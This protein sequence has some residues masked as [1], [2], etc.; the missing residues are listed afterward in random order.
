MSTAEKMQFQA[1]ARQVLDLMI[2]S[3]YTNK[4]IFLRELISNASDA[5]DRLRVESLTQKNILGK[6]EIFEIVIETDS[7]S[8]TVTVHDSGIGMTR[9]EVIENIGTIAKSGTRELLE[10]L[11]DKPN[12]LAGK[13]IGQFGVGFYAAFMVADKVSLLTRR[14]GQ[15]GATL[16]ESEGNGEYTISESTKFR[17]G[18][19]VTLH[20][21][22]KD[23]E[24]GVEDFTAEYVVGRIV[25]QYSDFVAYP[26]TL[27]AAGKKEKTGADPKP[28]NSMKPIWSRPASEVTE[29]DYTEFYKHISHDWNEPLTHLSFKAEGRIEYQSLL[30]LPSKAPMDL[31]FDSGKFGLQLYVRNVLI[32][33]SCEDLLPRYLRFVKG[34]VDSSDLPLNI[35]RQRLQEDRHIAQ[36]RKWITKKIIDALSDMA[37]DARDKYE[38]FWG[39]FGRV[40]KEGV[41]FD[42]GIDAGNDSGSKARLTP[43]L[44]FDSSVETGKKTTLAEYVERMQPEQ[45]NIFYLTGE[46]RETIEN[47]PHLEAFREKKIEVLFLTD[48]IDEM[49]VQALS[50]FDGKALKSVGKGTVA[51]GS[52]E[53]QN[54]ARKD[55][56]ARQVEYLD[57]MT[58]LKAKL[59]NHVKEVRLTNRLTDSPACLVVAEEDMSPR[60]ERILQMQGGTAPKQRRIMELNPDHEIVMKLKER[61]DGDKDDEAIDDFAELLFGGALLAEGSELKDPGRFSQS[62][63]RLMTRNL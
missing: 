43:L 17:R 26:I 34:V 61:V 31:F 27:E 54:Q 29:E 32:M 45:K 10:T 37:R 9:E 41:G 18:T 40:L 60:L 33:E 3:L 16:W 36:I 44:L 14:A 5:L 47:S 24:S 1:E 21:K 8:R 25:K 6:D 38:D 52:D 50:E 11:K 59:D 53:E 2:H 15:D 58:L 35:S 28:I 23:E 63:S 55:L 56:N 4:D 30:Y 46:S 57:L 19:S 22:P 49:M 12:E 48:P 20:L 42:F 62:L 7:E 51:L 39:H 13:L